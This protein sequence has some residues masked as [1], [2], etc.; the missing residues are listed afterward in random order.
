MRTANFHG[1][2]AVF[3]LA[4]FREKKLYPLLIDILSMPGDAT[5]ELF[6]DAITGAM[7]RILASVYDGD[8]EPLMRLTEN[9]AA[10]EFARGEALAALVALVFNQ[11]LT[12]AFVMDYM[13]QLL[14]GQLS[15]TGYYLNTQ[16]A[17]CCNALQSLSEWKPS[18][19]H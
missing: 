3:L 6:D 15:D 11:Q 16:I 7:G 9:P 14:G 1:M 17:C 12:R 19:A 13:K 18:T 10:N 2:Y 8:P 4:Q 5:E